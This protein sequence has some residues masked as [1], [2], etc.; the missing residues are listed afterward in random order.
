MAWHASLCDGNKKG[1]E[2][3]VNQNE[4]WMYDDK[5]VRHR[6]VWHV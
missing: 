5:D 4:R 3:K 6:C 2:G 1:C